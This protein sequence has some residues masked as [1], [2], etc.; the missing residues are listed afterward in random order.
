M[1][2][3][4]KLKALGLRLRK[5]R[6]SRNESQSVFA[7]RVG[8][9][10]PT[11]Y[12]MES[13]DPAITIGRWSNAL[14]ILDRQGDLDTVLQQQEDLFAKYEETITHTRKRASRETK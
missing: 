9:S 7:A 11:L 2:E 10:V 1:H 4:Q 3:D 8:V 14:F 12:K 5:E 13:G 6:L